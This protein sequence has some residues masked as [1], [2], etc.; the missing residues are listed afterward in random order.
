MFSY[1]KEEV[2]T[3]EPE[4][5]EF[6]EVSEDEFKDEFNEE[7]IAKPSN[8]DPI[9]QVDLDDLTQGD[10]L[11]NK[12]AQVAVFCHRCITSF[13]ILYPVAFLK[14]I[15]LIPY[16]ITTMQC[17]P[18]IFFSCVVLRKT[19]V[20]LAGRVVLKESDVDSNSKDIFTMAVKAVKELIANFI[21]GF[22]LFASFW[23][24]VTEARED[25]M[26]VLSGLFVGLA[27]PLQLRM[28]TSDE[29]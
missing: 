3:L 14:S 7:M 5:V 4:V 10:D 17:Y 6:S 19:T 2:K 18:T 25:M 27:F 23:T 22:S 8:I 1:F 12:A 16:N 29:L 20:L 26:I 28:Y 24:L 21:P 9:F 15:L 11:F 13:L